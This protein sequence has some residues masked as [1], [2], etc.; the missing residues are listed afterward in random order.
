MRVVLFVMVVAI[1]VGAPYLSSYNVSGVLN[2]QFANLL[3]GGSRIAVDCFVLLTG[4]F[5]SSS[6]DPKPARQIVRVLS[7]VAFYMLLYLPLFYLD[8]S[9]NLVRALSTAA[10]DLLSNSIYFYHLWY[11]QVI[12]ILYLLSPYMNVLVS[13]LP[14]ERLRNL[15]LVLYCVASV[16]PSI[17][18]ATGVQFYDLGLLNSRLTLFVLLYLVGAY[19]RKHLLTKA[20]AKGLFSLFVLA[21]MMVVALSFVY[22]SRHSPLIF[23]A[24]QRGVEMAYPLGGFS[25]AFYE[26]NNSLVIVAAVLMLL[27]FLQTKIPGSQAINRMGG[28]TYG[29]YVVHVFWITVLS[30]FVNPFAASESPR[31]PLVAVLLILSVAACS[32]ATEALRQMAAQRLSIWLRR[33]R[34]L[35]GDRASRI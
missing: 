11:T 22:N 8:S 20:S 14:K 3:D 35:F 5:L 19:V 23:F 33:P 10:V 24:K 4:Y 13:E 25:G 6:K 31:Y 7:P 26:F 18:Y 9:G 16:I 34:R 12:I 17:V 30:R 27:A 28:L 2:W 29:A 21:D 32:L 1:H 15:I